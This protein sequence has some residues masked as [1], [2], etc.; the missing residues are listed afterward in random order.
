MQASRCLHCRSSA[1][2]SH[3]RS[4][5][6]TRATNPRAPLDMQSAGL[7]SS[8]RRSPSQQSRQLC[9]DAISSRPTRALPS[10]A[11]THSASSAHSTL[12]A[13]RDSYASRQAG[14]SLRSGSSGAAAIELDSVAARQRSAAMIQR[15]ASATSRL[16][17]AGSGSATSAQVGFGRSDELTL[18]PQAQ[19]HGCVLC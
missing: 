19:R 4:A 7:P 17:P 10:A 1:A 2:T 9:G 8:M 12:V 13:Q 6:S 14:S 15:Q 11:A 16:T 5:S 3:R 18:D